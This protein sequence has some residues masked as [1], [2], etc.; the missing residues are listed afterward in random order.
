MHQVHTPEPRLHAQ[1]ARTAPKQRAH[2]P[3]LWLVAGRVAAHAR[4]CRSA[5]QAVSQRTLGRVVAHA[6][7]CRSS[8]Q[9]VSQY[10]PGRVAHT[11]SPRPLCALL[12]VSQ[13]PAPYSGA[14]PNRVVPVL[15]HNLAAKP[16]ACHDT[17]IRIAT[18]FPSSQALA[19]APLAL[20]RG[21]AVSQAMLAVS[22]PCCGRIAGLVA[23]QPS[24]VVAPRLR[25]GHTSPAQCHDTIHCIVTQMGSSPFLV[26]ASFFFFFF[27]HQIFFFI[28]TIGKSP[29]NIHT[30]IYIYIYVW[31]TTQKYTY[32]YIYIYFIFQYNQINLLKFI[33]SIFFSSFTHCKT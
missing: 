22:W 33:L 11:V 2:S 20:A 9:V 30:Y 19:C 13:L 26:S 4:P 24:R 1:A 10:T 17:P 25:P 14:S 6:R 27:S 23:R 5:R 3:M 18:Q 21:S 28:P 15:R 31:K 16:R 7:P 8:R 12:R 32:I 29:K